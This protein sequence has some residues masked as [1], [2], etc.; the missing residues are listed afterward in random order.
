AP[1]HSVTMSG[2][3]PAH[4]GIVANIYGVN[5]SK[6]PLLGGGGPG[7][8]PFRFKGSTL[9]DWMRAKDSS[10]RALSVSREHR[11]A[12]LPLGRGRQSVFWYACDGRF[13]TSTYY[14]DTLP[15]W[16]QQFNAKKIPQ[17]Y[18]LKWWT[19]LLEDAAYPEKD[20]V[21]WEADGDDIIFPH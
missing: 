16:V 7:A 5:D 11:V 6:W 17:T 19:L 20:S 14:A 4:T 12:I 21:K 15:N 10:S 13:T 9:I 8:A 1:G 18:A 3:F 2:R